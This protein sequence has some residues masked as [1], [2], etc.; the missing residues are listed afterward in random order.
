VPLA[1]EIRLHLATDAIVLWARM[2]AEA[3][4]AMAAPYWAS[5]WPGGQALARFVLDRPELVAGRRVMD[6]AAGSGVAGIAASLAG[7]SSVSAS[8]IDPYAVAAIG[9]NARA[10]GVAVAATCASMLDVDI[11]A[12]V[13][14][15]GDA[16]YSPPMAETAM[17]VLERATARGA[18]VL[19]GD[20]GRADLPRDR[21]DVLATYWAPYAAAIGD[22]E[23]DWLHVLQL[24]GSRGGATVP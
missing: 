7:A 9:E 16:F 18:R 2:E 1:P 21:L 10:N 17:T 13:V 19:V 6:L 14:L 20:P 23:L 8:D 5:A 15:V 24:K 22:A 11:D 3:G 4:S 12:D